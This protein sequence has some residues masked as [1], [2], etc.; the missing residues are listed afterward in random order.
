MFF[1]SAHITVT[2]DHGTA[3]LAF[4][5]GGVP[6]N[7]LDVEC[8]R[9]FETALNAVRSCPTVRILVIRSS[10]PAGFC[11][12]LSTIARQSLTHPADRA[13]FA[14][15]GQHVTA[16][17]ESLDAVSIAYIEG[18]CL[19]AGF[20]LALACDYRLC[21]TSPATPLGFPERLTCLGGS[22][23]LRALAGRRGMKLLASG[24]I[25]SGREARRLGL[26]DVACSERRAKIDLRAFLDRIE[27]RPAKRRRPLDVAGFAAERRTF[28]TA[29]LPPMEG[30]RIRS[31][32]DIS[33]R[34]TIGL[35]GNNAEAESLVTAAVL[36]GSSLI[37]CG[38]RS[39]IFARISDN[40]TRGYLTP[41]EAEDVRHRVRA[42]DTLDAFSTAAFVF[43]AGNHHPFKL[44][45][46]VC[47]RT[48]LCVVRPTNADQSG[49][50]ALPT[51]PFPFPRRLV[52]ISFCGT[53]RVAIFPDATAD[54]EMLEAI[55]S[56][57]KQFGYSCVVFPVAARLLPRAA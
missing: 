9:E 23:R 50:H 4:G 43:V 38:D 31:F 49:L 39:S 37:V 32:H 17:L 13:A 15:Y 28:S 46:A 47:P 54:T 33:A 3:T 7:V 12:G 20:E 11:A 35:L 8:L 10:N 34:E 42:T 14:W 51:V 18:P 21:V 25:V 19:G 53:N 26:V 40:M 5:F 41:L 29:P 30:V 16:V 6:A 48:V 1:E 27:E 52:H 55:T 2:S 56:W 36:R 24:S 22:S 57:F 44:A 45:A